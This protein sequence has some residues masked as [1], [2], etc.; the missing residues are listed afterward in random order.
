MHGGNGCKVGRHDV[1]LDGFLTV[2]EPVPLDI[3]TRVKFFTVKEVHLLKIFT[4]EEIGRR[5]VLVDHLIEYRLVFGRGV[6]VTCHLVQLSFYFQV[7]TVKEMQFIISV[8][9]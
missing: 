2:I 3:D 7:R 9:K 4:I 1:C 8:R 6:V 5:V